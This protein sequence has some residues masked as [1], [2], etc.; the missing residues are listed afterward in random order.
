METVFLIVVFICVAAFF[1]LGG[2]VMS[3][4]NAK[5]M[6]FA[7]RTG[8]TYQPMR[9]RKRP[10]LSGTYEGVEVD[11]YMELRDNRTYETNYL[12]HTAQLPA[13]SVPQ[14]LVMLHGDRFSEVTEMIAETDIQTGFDDIDRAFIIRGAD[15]REVQQFLISPQVRSSLLDLVDADLEITVTHD[16][17]KIEQVGIFRQFDIVIE[18]L[19]MLARC[20]KEIGATSLLAEDELFPDIANSP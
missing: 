15:P 17:I 4:T 20:A 11:I 8:M 9:W 6:E 5:M 16:A 19:E 1:L 14:G 10:R 7:R 18:R 13:N 2:A 3:R 12:I